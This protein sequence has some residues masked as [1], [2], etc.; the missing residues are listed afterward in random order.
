MQKQDFTLH[1]HTIGFDGKSTPEQMIERARD[2]GFKTIGI[3]NHFIV[4]PDIKGTKM[5]DAA[6]ARGYDTMYNAS[7][8]EAL[9]KFRPHYDELARLQD[10]NPDIRILRGMEVD[11]FPTD[12]WADGFK[13]IC[14]ILKP[15]YLIG[16]AHFIEY[17]GTV[18][19]VHDMTNAPA[20][21]R[22]EMLNIYWKNV[23]ELAKSGM[24]NW[25]AHMDL[26]K[27]LGLGEHE[28][29]NPIK[30]D[31]VE[32]IAALGTPV[33]INTSGYKIGT[34]QPYPGINILK[35]LGQYDVPMLISDDA[36]DTDRIGR[37]F[38]RAYCQAHEN[39]IKNFVSLQALLGDKTRVK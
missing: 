1:T 27:K 20:S 28:K 17:G 22:D 26:P 5:Y 9:A 32:T 12:A 29:W 15:D 30:R 31:T 8:D 4:H 3:S 19:N 39:G 34:K 2:M 37:D 35:M 10:K 11:R 7:F 21:T 14:E 6:M 18:C 13:R 25:I 24:F 33:E 36:H 23:Q 16:A 38:G